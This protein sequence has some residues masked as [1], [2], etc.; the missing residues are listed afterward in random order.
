MTGSAP[1]L[2]YL[3]LFSPHSS[4]VPASVLFSLS[5]L[6][7]P[8]SFSGRRVGK[9]KRKQTQAGDKGI[10]SKL[11]TL[12]CAPNFSFFLSPTPHC[13][14]VSLQEEPLWRRELL[15][16]SC[17]KYYAVLQNVSQFSRFPPAWKSCFPSSLFLLPYSPPPPPIPPGSHCPVPFHYVISDVMNTSIFGGQYYSQT[18]V[19]G[20]ESV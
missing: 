13:L 14:A 4:A 17:A 12:P 11:G 1:C 2:P 8:L 20:E 9:M 6:Y 18:L 10:Q 19:K 7:R 16:R 15:S 5:S 3:L